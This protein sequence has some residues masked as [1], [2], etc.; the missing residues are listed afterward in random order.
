MG[1]MA[2]TPWVSV[3]KPVNTNLG[4]GSARRVFH[5]VDP[6]AVALSL[7]NGHLKR[8]S[9]RIHKVKGQKRSIP[10]RTTATASAAFKDC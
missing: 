6:S 7:F 9:Y 2:M 1:E 8:V 3:D 4:S 5:G 10:W